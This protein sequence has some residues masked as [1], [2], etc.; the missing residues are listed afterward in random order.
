MC[1]NK[2]MYGEGMRHDKTLEPQNIYSYSEMLCKYV[3]HCITENSYC[4][5]AATVITASD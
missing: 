5:P 1:V 2:N 3:L 4:R